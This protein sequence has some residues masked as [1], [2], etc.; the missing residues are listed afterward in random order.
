MRR[1]PSGAGGAILVLVGLGV[2]AGCG[3]GP[4]SSPQALDPN[5]VP[6]GLLAPAST[7]TST[8]QPSPHA[9]V[10]YF[11]GTQRLVAV[12]RTVSGP[13]TVAAA[14]GELA[15]GPTAAEAGHGLTNPASSA[16]PIDVGRIS[17]GTV[18][19]DAAASFASLAGQSQIVAAAQIVFCA[20][21]VPGVTRVSLS[22]GG[23]QTEVPTAD[24]SLSPG[25]L[26][27]ADYASI[28]P[29]PG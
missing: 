26:T 4:Q 25:P 12:Q 6:F 8:T 22:V 21:S 20:T 15:Q 5:G 23:Q 13:L 24:G 1:R 16:A 14:L 29:A 17:D 19:I 2:L 28:G 7:T 11:E 27:R 3:V 9:V 10:V 18:S